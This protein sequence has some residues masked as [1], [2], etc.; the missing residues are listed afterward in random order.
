M[1][2]ILWKVP[3]L[4]NTV[5]VESI[6][7]NVK[8]WRFIK[9]GWQGHWRLCLNLLIPHSHEM[10]D[11]EIGFNFQIKAVM[12]S[13]PHGTGANIQNDGAPFTTDFRKS[14]VGIWF[15][16]GSGFLEMQI[17][18]NG[19]VLILDDDQLKPF[20][21]QDIPYSHRSCEHSAYPL[22]GSARGALW[23]S[24]A[25]LA[26]QNKSNHLDLFHTTPY[27]EGALRCT[28]KKKKHDTRTAA[29]PTE[30][31]LHCTLL[32]QHSHPSRF[33]GLRTCSKG[34]TSTAWSHPVVGHVC[35]LECY[36][37]HDAQFHPYLSGMADQK[38]RKSDESTL[39][40]PAQTQILRWKF[41]AKRCTHLS[42]L[43]DWWSTAESTNRY[44]RGYGYVWKCWVNI[45]NE[46]AIFHRDNDQQNHWVQWGTLFSDK[47]ILSTSFALMLPGLWWYFVVIWCRS[48]VS[49]NLASGPL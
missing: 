23:Y 6:T 22:F 20:K 4:Q 35:A 31:R 30:L 47:P 5:N 10:T 28:V 40:L 46:I 44:H 13:K 43:R 36:P 48:V 27:H 7:P 49:I 21:C 25:T 32:S 11:I 37:G 33:A 18:W 9:T 29:K 15:N 38:D 17:S 39:L 16:K 19:H 1:P 3:A 42:R 8:L 14:V 41:E 45:P 12:S 24:R 34:T 2:G 26:P